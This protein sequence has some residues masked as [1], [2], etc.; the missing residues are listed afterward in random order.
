MTT[1]SNCSSQEW[2]CADRLCIPIQWVCD[3]EQNCLDG[4]DEREGCTERNC[5]GFRCK[6]GQCILK[7]W[8]C[9]TTRH[10]KDGSDEDGCGE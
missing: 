8:R 2:R 3:G 5:E 7:E 6:D 1:A 9:D 4:S 10:C